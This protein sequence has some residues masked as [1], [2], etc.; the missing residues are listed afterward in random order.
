MILYINGDQLV[1]LDKLYSILGITNLLTDEEMNISNAIFSPAA[2]LAISDINYANGINT[3]HYK[4]VAD[5]ER[6][7]WSFKVNPNTNYRVVIDAKSSTSVPALDTNTPYVPWN[8]NSS[9]DI[10]TAMTGDIATWHMRLPWQGLKHGEIT[11]N[12]RNYTEVF[13][14]TNFG[15]IMDGIDTDITLRIKMYKADSLQDQINQISSNSSA[16]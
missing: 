13:L 2:K 10:E 14:T 9:Q 4:G 5:Y 16:K 15:Q 7:N 8:I 6:I 3:F 11:F 12:S 1:T